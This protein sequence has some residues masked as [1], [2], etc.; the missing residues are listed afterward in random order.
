MSS[1]TLSIENWPLVETT[2]RDGATDAD[3][4]AYF[5]KF[6]A[7]VLARRQRFA[8]LVDGSTATHPPTAQQRKLIADWEKSQLERGVA[9]NVGVAMV[10]TNRIVR[11]G[12]TALH[13]LFPPPTP[14]VALGSYDEAFEW[15]LARLREYDVPTAHLR[16]VAAAR[17]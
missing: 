5:A 14:T 17:R 8:S 6:E 2:L 7:Q 4:L 9:F 10:L 1:L 12:L 15:C 13:W 16:Q 3:Y 11:G